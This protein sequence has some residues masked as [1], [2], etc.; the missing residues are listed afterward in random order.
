M[1]TIIAKK[2]IDA[3]ANGA[4]LHK[5]LIDNN[6]TAGAFYT[7]LHKDRSLS[8]GYVRAQE[9]RADLMADE[10]I[11]IADTDDDPARAR[12]RIEAR[13]WVASKLHHKRYG[14]RIDMTVSATLDIT[15]TL[16]DARARLLPNSYPGQTIEHDTVTISNSYGNNAD[17]NQSLV[18]AVPAVP[19]PP[20]PFS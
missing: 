14:D 10:I 18:P 11:D 16:A 3:I 8:V 13:K 9:I 12:N 15:A 4:T 19:A 2:I 6:L 5:A 20:D 17:D 1:S 7:A